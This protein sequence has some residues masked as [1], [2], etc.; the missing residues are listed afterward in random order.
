MG[1]RYRDG[2]QSERVEKDSVIAARVCALARTHHEVGDVFTI[3]HIYPSIMLRFDCYQ[4]LLKM[5]G[6]IYIVFDNCRFGAEYR[7]RQILIT[8]EPAFALLGPYC[9]YARGVRDHR[10][11]R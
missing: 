2:T 4:S 9:T 1:V 11:A 5:T 7:H 10:H 6:V 8:N 3:E